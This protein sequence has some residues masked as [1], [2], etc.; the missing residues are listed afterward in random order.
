[1]AVSFDAGGDDVGV[2]IDTSMCFWPSS[3]PIT[4]T[5]ITLSK[6]LQPSLA[7][8]SSSKQNITYLG[9]ERN[10]IISAFL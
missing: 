6:C 7:C 4:L 8:N 10:L 5:E 3:V 2:V 9:P 1:M